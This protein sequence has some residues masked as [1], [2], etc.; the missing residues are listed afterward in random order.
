M[1][2]HGCKF[3]M[4]LFGAFLIVFTFVDVTS[5]AIKWITFGIGVVLVLHFFSGCKN[6]GN[7]CC[8]AKVPEEKIPAKK[9]K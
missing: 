4:L 7:G 8:G 5:A 1:D 6:M 2:N 3:A 9:K